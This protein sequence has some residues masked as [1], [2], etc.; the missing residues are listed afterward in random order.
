MFQKPPLVGKAGRYF[1]AT[2][3]EVCMLNI[4]DMKKS[5]LFKYLGSFLSI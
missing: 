5:A 3:K 4:M 1:E 2:S